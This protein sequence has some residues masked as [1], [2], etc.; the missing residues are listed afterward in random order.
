MY[1]RRSLVIFSQS[2]V[3][4]AR[5]RPDKLMISFAPSWF[6]LMRRFRL[7]REAIIIVPISA[8]MARLMI[9]CFDGIKSFARIFSSCSIPLRLIIASSFLI[10]PIS[11]FCAESAITLS[12]GSSSKRTVSS[13]CFSTLLAISSGVFKSS[14]IKSILFSTAMRRECERCTYFCHTSRSDF[15]TPVSMPS[16]YNTACAFGMVLYV[17]SG[18]RPSALRPGVST[19]AMPLVSNLCG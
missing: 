1:S 17:N 7:S 14:H 5:L 8:M 15:V 11:A 2:L 3:V 18:S 10:L 9:F 12:L 4:I 19:I 16:R 13:I 6:A